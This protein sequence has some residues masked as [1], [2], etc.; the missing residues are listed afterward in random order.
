MT[1]AKIVQEY[2]RHTIIPREFVEEIKK[3]ITV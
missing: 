3:D 2:I 1:D